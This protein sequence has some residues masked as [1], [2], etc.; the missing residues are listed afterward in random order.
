MATDWSRS[1]T[2][3]GDEASES[4]ATAEGLSFWLFVNAPFLFVASAGEFGGRG[5]R[6]TGEEAWSGCLPKERKD[7]MLRLVGMIG[8]LVTAGL[9]GEGRED[10]LGGKREESILLDSMDSAFDYS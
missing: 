5:F 9:G 10:C 1:L 6:F 2:N 3:K 8:R 4:V 7:E